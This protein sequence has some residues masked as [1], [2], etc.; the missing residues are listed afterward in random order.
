MNDGPRDLIPC[1]GI[2]R[3]ERTSAMPL[4]FTIG[5][6]PDKHGVF[7]GPRA[8]RELIGY[9]YR[10]LVL[11]VPACADCTG[12]LFSAITNRAIEM[13]TRLSPIVENCNLG[14]ISATWIK[15]KN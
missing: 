4:G 12:D 1:S 8:G 9:A 14:L 5:V 6:E 3:K 10:W 13:S 7:D 15:V 11:Y 2:I